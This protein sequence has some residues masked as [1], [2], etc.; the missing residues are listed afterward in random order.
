MATLPFWS[1]RQPSRGPRVVADCPSAPVHRGHAGDAPAQHAAGGARQRRQCAQPH[2]AAAGATAAG[3]RTVARPPCSAP[4]VAPAPAAAAAAGVAA[5]AVP[6]CADH[7]PSQRH[8]KSFKNVLAFTAVCHLIWFMALLQGLLVA[9]W[10]WI[11]NIT[12]MI[13]FI[14]LSAGAHN[15]PN[16]IAHR[17]QGQP[18]AHSPPPQQMGQHQA[19]PPHSPGGRPYQN[20]WQQ[21]APHPAPRQAGCQCLSLSFPVAT[22][23]EPSNGPLLAALCWSELRAMSRAMPPHVAISPVPVFVA[24]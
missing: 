7:Q 10:W 3:R 17:A 4:A 22:E 19:G 12:S 18:P 21:P 9:A 16:D 6:R 15:G 23:P 11:T 1:A 5:R 14:R 24:A 20:G 2:A 8:C 13:T